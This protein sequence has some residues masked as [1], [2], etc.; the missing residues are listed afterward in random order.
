MPRQAQGV[1]VTDANAAPG[2]LVQRA[3]TSG[4]VLDG[5]EKA[6]ML[7]ELVRSA[8]PH[9]WEV[10]WRDGSVGVYKTGV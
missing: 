6:T 2:M 9:M 5:S 7:G 4:A 8:G 3:Y 1:P 10:Q